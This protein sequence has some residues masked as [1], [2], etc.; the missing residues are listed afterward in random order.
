MTRKISNLK[1]VLG[2]GSP[3]RKQL[4]SEAGFH[5]VVRT[6]EIDETPPPGLVRNQIAEKLAEMKSDALR[7][8][9]APDEIL[10]TAD[11]IVCLGDKVLNK[12]LDESHAFEMLKALNGN[13][14]QVYT[15]VCIRKNGESTVFS[16][17]TDVEFNILSDEA[18]RDYIATCKP[19]DKA[20][21][22][23]AQESLPEGINPCSAD[24]LKFMRSIGKPDIFKN[25]LTTGITIKKPLIKGITGSY[26]NVMGLPIRELTLALLNE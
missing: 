7:F 15:G 14:H 21:S 16:V 12:P 19:F 10:I 11:T 2:S 22:Y 20:G 5:F 17:K 24:E 9:L 4:L 25:T 18:I 26:F 8:D 23:G 1:I 13:T 3:R 6:K